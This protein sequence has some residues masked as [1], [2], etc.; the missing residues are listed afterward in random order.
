MHRFDDLT[1]GQR[2]CLRLYHRGYQIKQ[3]ARQLGL[4]ISTVNQRL[5]RARRT[6]GTNN[7]REAARLFIEHEQGRKRWIP[8][9]GSENPLGSSELLPS[10]PLPRTDT[11]PRRAAFPARIRWPFPTRETKTNDMTWQAKLVWLIPISITALFAVTMVG[12]LSIALQDVLARS[13]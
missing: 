13:L 9:T 6:L 7:S 3:I 12:L 5:E 4:G 1:D 10:I 2:D 11:A 8:P